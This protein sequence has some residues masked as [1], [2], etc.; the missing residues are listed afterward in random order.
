MAGATMFPKLWFPL[1]TG[2]CLCVSWVATH[3]QVMSQSMK[4]PGARDVETFSID[5]NQP[6]AELLE[7]S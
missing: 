7:Q 2:R 6:L 3:V 5:C 4:I 1:R